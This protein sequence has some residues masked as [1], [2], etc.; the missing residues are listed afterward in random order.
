M[1]TSEGHY[2]EELLIALLDE[3]GED[4]LV[5]DP[6]IAAC[7]TCNKTLASVMSEHDV[8]ARLS[9]WPWTAG[10]FRGV[11]SAVLLPIAIFVVTRV[12]DKLI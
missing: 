1:M 5:R 9:T 3:G 4:A 8:L 11:A 12:I 10:T 2:D 6:H 7:T